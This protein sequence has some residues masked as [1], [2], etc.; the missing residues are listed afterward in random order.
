MGHDPV[1]VDTLVER[2]GLTADKVC[3]MQLEL[4]LKGLV[5]NCPGGT[6]IRLP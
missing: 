6:Y 1:N 4:E 5:E 3:S 2:S